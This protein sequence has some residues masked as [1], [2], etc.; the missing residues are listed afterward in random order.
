M[1]REHLRAFDADVSAGLIVVLAPNAAVASEFESIIERCYG[2]K[3][4][5]YLRTLDAIHLAS[6]RIS[7]QAEMVATDRRLRAAQRC[8]A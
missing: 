3:P 6:A 1:A 7:G 4:Q 8:S 2:A 5:I